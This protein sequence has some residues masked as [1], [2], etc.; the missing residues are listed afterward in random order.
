MIDKKQVKIHFSKNVETYDSYA[1]VQKLMCENLMNYIEQRHCDD[2]LNI[3][4][5]G[6]GT[7]FLTEMLCRKFPNAKITALDIAPGM[8]EY[9]DKKLNKYNINFICNDIEECELSDKYDFIISN[10]AF[11]WLNN[12]Q[13]TLK[14]LYDSLNYNGS[15]IFSTFG[16][17]TFQEL[18]DCYKRASEIL[19]LDTAFSSIQKFYT[20]NELYELC[21]NIIGIDKSAVTLNEE[22]KYEYFDNCLNFLYSIK[23]VGANGCIKQ[24]RSKPKLI[25]KVIN[26]YDKDYRVN[27]EIVATY[28]CLFCSIRKYNI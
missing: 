22:M 24:N 19:E 6:C 11:Q 27:N 13:M 12:M 2:N 4:E 23:R 1:N 18:N 21:T 10:A 5:I 20:I 25:K 7:G 3:L 8:I 14:K 9:A 26:I 17:K 28:H 15:I 16:E